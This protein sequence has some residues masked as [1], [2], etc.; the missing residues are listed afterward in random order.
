MGKFP[1]KRPRIISKKFPELDSSIDGVTKS[2]NDLVFNYREQVH[3]ALFKKHWMMAFS[4]IALLLVLGSFISP[5][6]KADTNI[7]YPENCLGGWIN[8]QHAQGEPETDSNGDETQFTKENSAVLP[9]NT[10]AQMYCG[11]F[12]GTFDTATKPTKIV[13]SLSLTKGPDLTSEEMLEL[14]TTLASTSVS[15]LDIASSTA[16]T[17]Q[18]VASSTDQT[19]ATSTLQIDTSTTTIGASTTTED[20]TATTSIQAD[21]TSTA[22]SIETAI[23]TPGATKKEGP[24]VLDGIIQS[25]QDTIDVIF[26]TTTEKKD[27]TDTVVVPVPVVEEKPKDEQPQETVGE[28]ASTTSMVPIQT[29]VASYITSH[30]IDT[31]FAQEAAEIPTEST[32]TESEPAQVQAEQPTTPVVVK[33]ESAPE[34]TASTQVETETVPVQMTVDSSSTDNL[35]TDISVSSTTLVISTSSEQES[36]HEVSESVT[37]EESQILN[38]GNQFQNN[39]LDVLYSFDGITWTSLGELNEIS[40]KYRTFEIPVTATTSW[41]KL[42]QLQIKVEA[43]KLETETPTVYLDGIKV[44]VLFETPTQ[45]EHPD[46]NRDTILMDKND[47]GN[48]R[49]VSIINSDTNTNEIWYTTLATQGGYGVAPGSWVKVTLGDPSLSYELIDIYGDNI[50]WIDQVQ[51]LLWV[52]N[53]RKE[54]NDGV[55]LV[56]DA[57]TT[58]DFTKNDGEEWIFEYSKETNIS[59]VKRKI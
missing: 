1:F 13:V 31:V 20:T 14:G 17:T 42:Q 41:G 15:V 23:A 46:F 26:K 44:D 47:G 32:P 45:H 24:S 33:E 4:S 2:L 50:F 30:F 38:D 5:K 55:G 54:T 35:S 29:K 11:N 40:M 3:T 12:K 48:I 27:Q 18:L 21:G 10:E 51:Q 25:V 19:Q 49:V 58:A 57:T 43:K 53:L 16:S 52:S 7:F 8:P 39:F 56:E 59:I 22:Q 6:G 37:D 36:V 34:V 9:K 28:N